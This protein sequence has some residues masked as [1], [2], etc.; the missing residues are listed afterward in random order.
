[1]SNL[2]SNQENILSEWTKLQAQ[3]QKTSALW[4]DSAKVRFEKEFWQEYEPI[5]RATIKQ[6]ER[7]DQIV[8]QAK[9]EVKQS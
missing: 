4:N 3:W 2:R 5:I 9:R 7:L 1:M 8:D 6:L